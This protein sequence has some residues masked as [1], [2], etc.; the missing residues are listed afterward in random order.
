MITTPQ[1]VLNLLSSILRESSVDTSN[2]RVIYFERAVREL[3]KQKKFPWSRER[4]DYAVS[5]NTDVSI[6]MTSETT[7]YNPV[8]GPHEVWN[9]TEQIFPCDYEDRE[10]HSD[11]RWYLE[12]DEKTIGFTAQFSSAATIKVYYYATIPMG[13]VSASDSS[14]AFAIPDDAGDVV[15]TY[16]KFLVHDGKRQRNDARNAILDFKQQVEELVAQQASN[17]GRSNSKR[18]AP[19]LKFHGFK[20][21]Y[22][23]G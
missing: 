19:V 21:Q 15:A 17:K 6:D 11:L 5:A 14:L 7:N 22:P 8:W 16:M 4:L 9:G 12:P 18:I 10:N 1:P 20:R 23:N 3:L 13:S 2:R